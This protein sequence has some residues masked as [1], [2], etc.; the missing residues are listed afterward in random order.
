[1]EDIYCSGY[2]KNATQEQQWIPMF[3]FLGWQGGSEGEWCG[4]CVYPLLQSLR[5]STVTGRTPFKRLACFTGHA[6]LQEQLPNLPKSEWTEGA[7]QQSSYGWR[8]KPPTQMYLL[9][10][11]EARSQK[12]K[13]CLAVFLRIPRRG[14]AFLTSLLV[15]HSASKSRITTDFFFISDQK[16]FWKLYDLWNL[17]WNILI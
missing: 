6:L 3:T 9:V 8:N 12:S 17:L 15:S 4:W 14:I 10:T 1:M 16:P 7:S 5:F 2:T 13:C 11:W